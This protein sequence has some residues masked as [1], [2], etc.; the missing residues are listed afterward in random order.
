MQEF[1]M[2]KLVVHDRL[3]ADV[4]HNRTGDTTGQDIVAEDNRTGDTT[5]QDIVAEDTLYEICH[6]EGI[7]ICR[8]LVHNFCIHRISSI[9]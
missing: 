7:S 2:Q 8:I 4:D 3:D 1:Y 9:S 5:G 6:I